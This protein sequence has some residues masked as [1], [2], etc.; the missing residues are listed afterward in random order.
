[1]VSIKT[2][3]Q[4]HINDMELH[5]HVE[6]T[7]IEPENLTMMSGHKQFHPSHETTCLFPEHIQI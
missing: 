2:K 6:L 7:S 3:Q 4:N 5:V 1:M